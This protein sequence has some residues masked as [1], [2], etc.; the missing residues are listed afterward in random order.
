MERV[1]RRL[2]P[3]LLLLSLLSVVGVVA[4]LWSDAGS[5]PQADSA[6]RTPA[7]GE[8]ARDTESDASATPD[9]EPRA[10][11]TSPRDGEPTP[12]ADTNRVFG[13][14][15]DDIE[16]DP[17][18]D[19]RVV[20][21]RIPDTTGS[22]QFLGRRHW[23][24]RTTPAT[25][26]LA[27]TTTDAAGLFAFEDTDPRGVVVRATADGRGTGIERPD[28]NG[29]TVIEIPP[30][31]KRRVRVL[32]TSDAPVNSAVAYLYHSSQTQPPTVVA[33]PDDQGW[34]S[35]SASLGNMLAVTAPGY[36]TRWLFFMGRYDGTAIV[37]H[38]EMCVSG[39]V[40]DGAGKGVAGALVYDA[41][42]PGPPVLT[43]AAGNFELR[44]LTAG[45]EPCIVTVHAPGAAAVSREVVP[46][47]RGVQIVVRPAASVAGVVLDVDGAP[48][49]D[50]AVSARLPDGAQRWTTT[51]DEGRFVFAELPPEEIRLTCASF[52]RGAWNAPHPRPIGR[53]AEE[54]LVSLRPGDALVNV[55]LRLAPIPVSYVFARLVGLDGTAVKDV[56]MRYARRLG[57]PVAFAHG[58]LGDAYWHVVAVPPGTEIEARFECGVG[59]ELSSAFVH[60]VTTRAAPEGEPDEIEIPRT[61]GETRLHLVTTCSD[62]RRLGEEARAN[63]TVRQGNEGRRVAPGKDGVSPP[64]IRRA[65]ARVEARRPV[66]ITAW[67]NGCGTVR[68][69][70]EDPAPGDRRVNCVLPPESVV[71]GNLVTRSGRPVLRAHIEV[72]VTLPDGSISESEAPIEEMLEGG[73]F[74]ADQLAGGAGRI[75]VRDD[76]WQIIAEQTFDVPAESRLDLGAVVV[77]ALPVVSGVVL[78]DGAP[79]SGVPIVVLTEWGEQELAT[80]ATTAGGRFSLAVPNRARARFTVGPA[81]E[82]VAYVLEDV[83]AQSPVRLRGGRTGRLVVTGR[84]RELPGRS[85]A[86]RI[87]GGPRVWGDGGNSIGALSFERVPAGEIELWLRLNGGEERHTRITVAP[88]AVTR[89]RVDET[90]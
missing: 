38:P 86:I 48:L 70:I 27:E 1:S 83:I 28:R 37:L 25:Q 89:V 47:T 46:G 29:E 50:A 51:D 20:L 32:D 81:N 9:D 10:R 75:T 15:W 78:V 64:S 54:V 40:V 53:R 7:V 36:A 34:V 52:F 55:S 8:A 57:D 3:P 21:V 11:V 6:I 59:F 84:I 68:V 76:R 23:Y 14:V 67:A 35:V 24:M 45:T 44:G 60:T 17:V 74:V 31:T 63:W 77:G 90:E 79:A 56:G 12:D 62:G 71:T 19:A 18:A 2:L 49:P 26:I 13:I 61:A 69:R 42:N 66:E 43:G 41:E 87:P 82:R 88:G 4:L 72:V 33:R 30:A 58:T 16:G 39:H 65:L 22:E 80:G 73:A 5:D 85:A